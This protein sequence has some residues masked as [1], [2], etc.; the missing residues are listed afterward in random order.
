MYLRYMDNL[1][2]STYYEEVKPKL[3]AKYRVLVEQCFE[4]MEKEIDPELADDKLHNVLKA[5]RMASEDA[6]FYA[7]EIE[8]LENEAK[9]VEVEDTKPINTLKKYTKK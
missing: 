9:G 7:K 1:E 4:I 6:K 2:K 5:K 3:I 8:S